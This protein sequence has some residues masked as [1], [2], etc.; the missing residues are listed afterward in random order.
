MYKCALNNQNISKSI[1]E[2][3]LLS[4]FTGEHNKL[5]CLFILNYSRLSKSWRRTITQYHFESNKTK[6]SLPNSRYYSAACLLKGTH[7]FKIWLFRRLYLKFWLGNKKLLISKPL[8][9]IFRIYFCFAFMM[10]FAPSIMFI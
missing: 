8:L 2:M 7:T 6:W 1:L 9:F 3:Y 4:S 10:H 5:V